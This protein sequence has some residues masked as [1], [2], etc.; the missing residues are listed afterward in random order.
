MKKDTVLVEHSLDTSKP[1]IVDFSWYE[2]K[3]ITCSSCW[4]ECDATAPI[5]WEFMCEDCVW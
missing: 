1:K 5:E 2:N 3:L 4:E